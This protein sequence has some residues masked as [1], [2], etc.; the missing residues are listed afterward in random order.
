MNFEELRAELAKNKL[1][2]YF[3][4]SGYSNA[5]GIDNNDLVQIYKPYWFPCMF[6]GLPLEIHFE[7]Q[8]NKIMRLDC[9]LYPYYKF[10]NLSQAELKIKFPQYENHLENRR[11]FI[12]ELSV[13]AQSAYPQN[14]R[15]RQ[16]KFNALSG[17]EWKW[18]E[19]D[20]WNDIAK[21]IAKILIAVSPCVENHFGNELNNY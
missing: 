6:N 19:S 17:I 11:N 13:E 1:L 20:D 5:D 8:S 14:S 18:E 12:R 16:V 7:V 9:H 21:G 4:L 10:K 2:N 15:I 3:T